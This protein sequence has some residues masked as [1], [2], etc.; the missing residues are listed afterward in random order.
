MKVIVSSKILGRELSK[1]DFDAGDHIIAVCIDKDNGFCVMSKHKMLDPIPCEIIP[2]DKQSFVEQ[3]NRRWDA[4]AKTLNK[5][6]EQPVVLDI[7][8]KVTSLILQY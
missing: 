7:N 3:Y 1:V 6:P 4:I 8:E 2:Y 5:L